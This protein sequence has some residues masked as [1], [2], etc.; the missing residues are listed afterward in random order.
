MRPRISR[1]KAAWISIALICVAIFSVV[2]HTSTQEI[3]GP[4]DLTSRVGLALNKVESYRFTI[5]TNLSVPMQKGSIQMIKGMGA[6]DYRDQEIHTRMEL[7]NDSMEVYFVDNTLYT[8]ESNKQWEVH[9][10]KFNQTFLW[11][12]NY[13]QLFRQRSILLN[14]TNITM[15]EKEDVWV[16][17]V[18]PEKEAVI[19]QLKG[20]EQLEGFKGEQLRDVRIRYWID[21]DT[22][23]ITRMENSMELEMNIQGLITPVTLNTSIDFFEY[24]NKIDIKPPF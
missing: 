20:S 3:S 13:D 15:H 2:Y 12:N 7:M 8:R 19:Q 24:N 18:L 14:A 10:Q 5:T 6:V 9:K 11:R 21:K 1:G 22:F 17:E 16:L 4:G 23:Y